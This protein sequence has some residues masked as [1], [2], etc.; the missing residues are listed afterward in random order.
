VFDTIFGL[1]MHVLVVHFVVALVPLIAIATAAIAVVPAWRERWIGWAVLANAAAVILAW[2]ARLSGQA[3]IKRL[4]RLSPA[5]A[6]IT[7]TH[8]ARGLNLIWFVLALFAVSL[9]LYLLGRDSKNRGL[10][11]GI[12]TVVAAALVVYEV[13]LTGHS[14]SSAVWKG[15]VNSP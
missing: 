4:D 11:V 14:G 13:I 9:L 1:P 12:V 15:V 2:V 5:Y 10:V 8:R 7:K 3:F 6:E